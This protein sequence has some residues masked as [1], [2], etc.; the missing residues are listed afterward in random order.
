[1][2]ARGTTPTLTFTITEDD[3]TAFD[4]TGYNVYLTFKSNS[5]EQTFTNDRLL[6]VANAVSITLT[7]E[8]TLKFRQSFNVQL[9]FI[10]NGVALATAITSTSIYDILKDGVIS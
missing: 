7:Q 6:I 3:G 5:N 9:R 2:I 10:K 1:M 8:E 4:L